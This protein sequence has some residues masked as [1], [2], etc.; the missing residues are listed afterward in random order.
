[1]NHKNDFVVC[2]RCAHAPSILRLPRE[3][4]R[5]IFVRI[6]WLKLADAGVT[7]AVAGRVESR[8]ACTVIHLGAVSIVPMIL[9]IPDRSE[10]VQSNS[11]K[12]LSDGI[13]IKKKTPYLE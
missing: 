8:F 10:L 7:P 13:E 3:I 12:I 9:Q 1:M 5:A 6:F 4:E 2:A 11:R